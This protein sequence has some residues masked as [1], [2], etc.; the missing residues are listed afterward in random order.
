MGR[1]PAHVPPIS[2]SDW[3]V[4]L[5]RGGGACHIGCQSPGGGPGT[6][7]LLPPPAAPAADVGKAAAGGWGPGVGAAR[8]RGGWEPCGCWRCLSPAAGGRRAARVRPCGAAS[9]APRPETLRARASAT[10]SSM[11]GAGGGERDAGAWAHPAGSA[12][13]P[14]WGR[15]GAGGRDAGDCPGCTWTSRIA[16]SPPPTAA[17]GIRDALTPAVQPLLPPPWSAPSPD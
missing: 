2:A 6:P 13:P 8:K 3:W 1:A 10:S 4:Y 14:R 9:A 15:P 5:A 12:S 16:G 7:V 17:A 11:V